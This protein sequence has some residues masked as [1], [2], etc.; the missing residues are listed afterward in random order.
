MELH[1]LICIEWRQD[2][3]LSRRS[4]LWI[5]EHADPADPQPIRT[6]IAQLHAEHIDAL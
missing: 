3:I 1:P 5:H 4:L 2:H 6:A